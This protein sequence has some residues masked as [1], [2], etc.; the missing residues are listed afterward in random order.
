MKTQK[1]HKH[2]RMIVHINGL[3]AH[4]LT[5]PHTHTHTHT[6][7]HGNTQSHPHHCL[8]HAKKACVECIMFER[9]ACLLIGSPPSDP[10][11]RCSTLQHT[12]PDCDRLRQTAKDCD[13]LLH[14][15][16]HCF[17]LRHT[18]THCDTLQHTCVAAFSSFGT[19]KFSVYFCS[20]G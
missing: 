15:A 4:T 6:H 17:T 20:V 18:A 5:H 14:T 11:G 3:S 12:M 7:T 13:T 16:S 19:Q 8:Q 9:F 2:I 1:N 10:S